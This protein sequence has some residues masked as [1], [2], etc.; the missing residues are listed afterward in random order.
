M[1]S[2]GHTFAVSSAKVKSSQSLFDKPPFDAGASQG[3]KFGDSWTSEGST[4]QCGQFTPAGGDMDYWGLIEGGFLSSNGTALEGIL[5][6][7][8]DCSQT[9]R[10][11]FIFQSWH[12]LIF[13]F[14]ITSSTPRRASLS[15]L[16]PLN[17]NQDCARQQ[18]QQPGRQI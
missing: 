5:H 8:D 6:A 2:Y 16:T 10:L 12:R 7:F 13:A 14:R 11:S 1:A 15:P 18:Q 3:A 17:T 9:V 4:D